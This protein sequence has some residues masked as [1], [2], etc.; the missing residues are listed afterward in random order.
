M[1]SP[2]HFSPERVAYWYL[3][4][5]GFLQIENFVVHPARHGSQR[6][7]AGL[8][9]VRF[10]HRSEFLYDQSDPMVDDERLRLSP[11]FDDIVITEVKTNQQC[12]LNGP[13][14][15]SERKNAARQ[16]R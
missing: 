11:C 9:G 1:K 15:K 16:S 12:T 13:W 3:R 10:R 4:L 14:T 5:N 7:D 8:L 6:T 2:E